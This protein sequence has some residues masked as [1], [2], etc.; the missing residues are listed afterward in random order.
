MR[1]SALMYLPVRAAS[2]L[3]K[4]PSHRNQNRSP[5][6]GKRHVSINSFFKIL[7]VIALLGGASCTYAQDVTTWHYDNSRS[8]VQSHE[9][10]LAPAKVNSADFGKVFSLPVIGDIYAQPLYLSQYTMSDGKLHNVLLVATAQDYVYAFDADGKNPSQGYLWRK[11]LVGSGETWLSY[12]DE[13]SDFDIYPNIGIISTPVVNRSGGTVY[14]LSR[15]KTTSGTT[16]YFQRLH[17]LNI[18][19]G[20]EKLGGP[21]TIQ[22]TVAGLG[23]GGTT[24]SFEPRIHNQRAALLLAP[25]P[26]VGS[27]QSIFLAWASHGDQGPYHGW[28]IAYDAANIANQNG[29]WVDTPNGTWGGIWMAGGG[30]SSDNNGNV[31]IAAGNGTFDANNGGKDYGSS[32]FRLTLGSSGIALGDYFTPGNFS[33][34]NANDQDMGT[35]ALT[36]LPTQSGARPHLGVTVD[37]SGTIYLIDRDHMGGFTTP[38]NASVQ[39]FSGGPYKNRSSFA[40]FNNIMYG[41]FAGAPLQAWSFNPSTGLFNTTPQSKSPNTYGCN[42][43]GAG[44][45]P[46]VSASGSTNGI[47][48][49]LDN[50]GFYHTPAILYAYDASNLGTQLYN[51]TQAAN[52]RDA[53]AVAVKFTTPTVANGQVYVGGRNAVTVYGLLS[54]GGPLTAGPTFSPPAGTYSSA[55]SVTLADSTP[56][57]SIYYT[58]NG[59][60][61]STGSTLYT[62]PIQVTSSE[63]INAVAIAPGFSQSPNES[64]SYTIGSSSSGQSAVSLASVA[65]TFGIY[66]DGTAFTTGGMD[67]TGAAYSANLL[68]TSLAYAGTTYTIGAANQKDVVKGIGAPVIPLTAGSFTSL[69]FLGSGLNGGQASQAFTVTYTDGTTTA[70][71]QSLSDW[72]TKQNFA[73]EVVARAMT[74]RNLSTGA[75][76][77]RTFNLYQYSFALNSAKTVKSL[78]LPSNTNVAVVALTLTGG[79]SGGTCNPPSSP[80][81]NV[82]APVNGSTVSSPVTAQ[83]KATI[84]GTL[85]RMEVWVDGVK[86]FTETTS[87]TLS[88]SITLATGSHRFDFYAVNTAGTKW[89]KTVNATVK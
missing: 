5:V 75:K 28:V 23:N 30:P 48:W 11:F 62:G 4:R 9:T 53:A 60:P 12:L 89:L 70:F 55:Q 29:A 22:A 85:A 37:K 47:V 3:S 31:F 26:S 40:F 39:S 51:S 35:G 66:T 63:T 64:A 72:F 44:S 86:K 10:V 71:T 41:G 46:S 1:I 80:G 34:L 61:A 2:Q 18:A 58:T 83:A 14:V 33:S 84:T 74:Y 6:A 59:T 68:G 88:T 42:C 38:G 56:N 73:G 57:A 67:G 45:T 49:T 77:N 16:Q 52:S 36:L 24:I 50:S 19:D 76:D 15:S 54:T 25:T 87:T 69:K 32:A 27:G 82:C 65:N 78:T 20:A 13:N 79:S 17:A 21:T 43:N 8:G 81:V 7:Q